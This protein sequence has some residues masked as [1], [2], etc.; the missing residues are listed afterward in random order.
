[1][2][3]DAGGRQVLSAGFL[4][5]AA[6]RGDALP[7]VALVLATGTAAGGFWAVAG[8]P[9]S[10]ALS[11]VRQGP[12][13]HGVL[14]FARPVAPVDLATIARQSGVE[15]EL[16]IPDG[17]SR[18]G[19][20]GASP[21]PDLAG[22]ADLQQ[23]A[24]P[25]LEGQA[26][27]LAHLPVAERRARLSRQR[28]ALAL[29]G[30]AAAAM[31]LALWPA[32]RRRRAATAVRG[33]PRR[34]DAAGRDASALLLAWLENAAPPA[35]PPASDAAAGVTPCPTA[36]RRSRACPPRPAWRGCARS[37]ARRA[38]WS[39]CCSSSQA[40]LAGPRWRSA[41]ARR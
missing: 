38:A 14:V 2:L 20:T 30:V 11:P 6:E 10:V 1:M 33:L 37:I 15:V 41:W 22:P 12:L 5:A 3:F 18:V 9:A 29:G 35:P 23:L 27:I 26:R 8:L 36:S 32:W 4:Q 25:D 40:R 28:T 24:L 19:S 7:G 31:T 21:G 17:R 16:E 34:E 13:L 39:T